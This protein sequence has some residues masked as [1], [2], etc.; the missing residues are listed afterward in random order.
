MLP[1]SDRGT[2]LED[3]IVDKKGQSL[4]LQ[5]WSI[6]AQSKTDSPSGGLNEESLTDPSLE[7]DRAD[8]IF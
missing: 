3:V 1:K 7:R 5:G 6:T 8:L 4:T 2:S